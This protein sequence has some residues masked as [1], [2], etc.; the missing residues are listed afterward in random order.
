MDVKQKAK[1][2][3]NSVAEVW[4]KSRITTIENYFG[5]IR[6]LKQNRPHLFVEKP[7]MMEKLGDIKGKSVLT[8][9]CGSGEECVAILEK[10]PKS[11]TGVDIAE[12]LIEIAKKTVKNVEFLV[13][14]VEEMKFEDQSFD[15][16]YCSLMMDYFES[17]EKVLKEV[18]RVLRPGGIFL[19]SGLHPVKWSAESIKDKD[20]KSTISWMGFE[21]EPKTGTAKIHGD[22]LGTILHEEVWNNGMEISY[23]TKP[24]SLMFKEIRSVGFNVIDISEPKAIESAKK[25]DESYWQIKQRIP[26]FV[27]FE[28][29]K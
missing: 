15:L 10:Q 29:Q 13:M 8:I 16:V 18:Y 1:K 26:D 28:C 24:I 21:R 11:I 6:L 5:D 7:A 2:G 17:W 9:G 22:Y 25:H 27:V 19:F 14:D 12:N 23:F 20:G 4:H 3:Y